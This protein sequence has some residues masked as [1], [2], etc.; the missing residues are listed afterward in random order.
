MITVKYDNSKG[1]KIRYLYFVA[2]DGETVTQNYTYTE[3]RLI[4]NNYRMM[5][6]EYNNQSGAS[7]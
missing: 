2:P 3:A 7:F 1:A 6:I 4:I 5:G